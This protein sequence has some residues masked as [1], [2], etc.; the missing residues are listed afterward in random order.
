M[1][2]GTNNKKLKLA[3]KP[4]YYSGYGGGKPRR[5]RPPEEFA[6]SVAEV[7]AEIE[8]WDGMIWKLCVHWWK[9]NRRETTVE[10][11]RQIMISGWMHA[12]LLYDKRRKCTFSS[13]AFAWGESRIRRFL[14]YECNRGFRKPGMFKKL[15][16]LPRP[17]S[18]NTEFGAS[19]LRFCDTIATRRDHHAEEA[20]E[21]PED[22]WY[23]VYKFLDPAKRRVIELR[24]QNEMTLE[25]VAS[26]MG[27]T[28]ARV[29]QLEEKAIERIRKFV[30]FGSCVEDL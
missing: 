19:G 25:E 22:F 16:R 8:K 24:Y 15:A 6:M 13:Y 29:G 17:V 12:G 21:F 10:E 5:F 27:I 11:L 28:R 3:S 18:A 1:A 20:P 7:H 4:G 30:D 23:R 26:H 14:I 9:H 2:T